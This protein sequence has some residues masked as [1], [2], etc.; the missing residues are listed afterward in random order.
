[1]VVIV[2]NLNERQFNPVHHQKAINRHMEASAHFNSLPPKHPDRPAAIKEIHLAQKQ[3]GRS[4][5]RK[6]GG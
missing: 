5:K 3:L 2:S 4:M 1:M 6:Y